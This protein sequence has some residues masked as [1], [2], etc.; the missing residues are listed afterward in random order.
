MHYYPEA[1]RGEEG[2]KDSDKKCST[3][4]RIETVLYYWISAQSSLQWIQIN[5]LLVF[6]LYRIHN[7]EFR[8]INK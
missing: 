1:Q 7:F 3:P 5:I 2:K 4:V 6:L 8:L